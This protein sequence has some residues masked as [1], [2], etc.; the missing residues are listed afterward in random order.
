MPVD[1][2]L[3][4]RLCCPATKTPL[5]ELSARELQSINDRISA[6]G[7][8]YENGEP[9]EKPLE[10]GLITSDGKTIY[11]IR[12]SIPIMLIEKGIPGHQVA[13]L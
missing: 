12:N 9:V 6:G 1:K 3:L 10:E 7:V 11:E 8:K 13:G 2:I 5:R 4:E